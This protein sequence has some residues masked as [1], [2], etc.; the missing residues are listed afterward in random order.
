MIMKRVT[1]QDQKTMAPLWCC[2]YTCR[3]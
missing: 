1:I 3:E 2:N